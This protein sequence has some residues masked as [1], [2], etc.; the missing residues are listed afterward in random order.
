MLARQHALAM[1]PTTRKLPLAICQ[2]TYGLKHHPM[3]VVGQLPGT[4][5]G[6]QLPPTLELPGTRRLYSK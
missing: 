1:Y 3:S 5:T 4:A 6:H 2:C